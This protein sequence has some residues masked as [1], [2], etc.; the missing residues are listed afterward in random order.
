MSDEHDSWMKS[1]LGIDIGDTLGK[2][3]DEAVATFEKVED[4]IVQVV[5]AG[6]AVVEGAVTEV[7]QAVGGV[8]QKV[9]NAVSPPS[10]SPA[11]VA[12]GGGTGSFPLSASVGRGGTNAPGDVRAVQGAL[13][14]AADGKCGG[15]TIA[16][17]E[18][19]QRRI[20]QN[21]PDGRV[22]AGGGTERAL[23]G[24]ASG[25]PAAAPAKDENKPESL[26]DQAVQG[27][28]NIGGE[29]I[30][31]IGEGVEA[32]KAFGGEAVSSLIDK[33]KG[34]IE[35]AKQGVTQLAG[36][37][38]D[39]AASLLEGAENLAGGALGNIDPSSLGNQISGAGKKDAGN[40]FDRPEVKVEVD[41]L[42][43]EAMRGLAFAEAGDALTKF[44]AAAAAVRGQLDKKE[45][46]ERKNEQLK[47][48]IFVALAIVVAT[49]LTGGAAAAIAGSALQETLRTKIA[50]EGA[51]MLTKVGVSAERAMVAAKSLADAAA[52][53]SVTRLAASYSAADGQKILGEIVKSLSKTVSIFGATDKFTVGKQFIAAIEDQVQASKEKLNRTIASTPKFDDLL[54]IYHS[55]LSRKATYEK[56]ISTQVTQFMDQIADVIVNRTRF[57]NGESGVSKD[58]IVKM[59]AYGRMRYARTKKNFPSNP[60]FSASVTYDFV[61]WIAP[62]L[63]AMAEKMYS[64]EIDPRS[65]NG[66]LPDPGVP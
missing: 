53:E 45:Q 3:K 30:N 34:L 43:T 50:L 26:F 18:D 31:E 10:A 20:G 57:A 65:I 56:S 44:F 29:V 55:C 8:A 47:F 1:A 21:K 38:Q 5:K 39:G 36:D 6:E 19:F 24:G 17:I 51:Q 4:K 2:I 66:H 27:A 15:G 58:V 54:S 12:S 7:T 64:D 28:K 40:P 48:E 25:A 16:A 49:P 42:A 41:K 22:D 61:A 63:E 13:G 23:A 60:I 33:G 59:N 52:S 32:A 46:E 9:A 62:E 35:D 11:G 14:I 37:I